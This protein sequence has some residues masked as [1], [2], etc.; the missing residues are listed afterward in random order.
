[1]NLGDNITHTT[2]TTN[3]MSID[4]MTA[5]YPLIMSGLP[6]TPAGTMPLGPHGGFPAHAQDHEL[7]LSHECSLISSWTRP[8]ASRNQAAPS[9]RFDLGHHYLGQE[10]VE[11]VQIPKGTFVFLACPTNPLCLHCGKFVPHEECPVISIHGACS[12]DGTPEARSAVCVR[13][14]EYNTLNRF[15]PLDGLPHHTAQ[16]AELYAVL[17]ALSYVASNLSKWKRPRGHADVPSRVH[18]VVIKTDSA[19]MLSGLTEWLP[20]W[21]GNGWKKS[22]G[23]PVANAD[24][25]K[26]I[27]RL[28]EHLEKD[29]CV[30]F[31]LVTRDQ[32][33]TAVNGAL[34]ALKRPA[35]PKAFENLRKKWEEYT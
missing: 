17:T 1:M 11:S 14:G 26:T 33:I 20:K 21:K 8:S 27:D 23:Q 31:W 16:I 34:N 15:V 4:I 25:W 22:K 29:I 32:N 3:S 5:N 2:N 30:K 35:N 24:C 9:R 19:H 10:T 28:L 12:N 6:D 7:P 13:V 18:T